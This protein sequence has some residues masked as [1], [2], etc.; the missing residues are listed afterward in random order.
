MPVLPVS[1]IAVAGAVAIAA[2]ALDCPSDRE[3]V[4]GWPPCLTAALAILRLLLTALAVLP[5]LLTL[6]LA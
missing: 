6:P 2:A 4:A 3:A 5:L 1:Y